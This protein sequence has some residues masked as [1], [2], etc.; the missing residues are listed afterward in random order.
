[1]DFSSTLITYLIIGVTCVISFLAFERTK[2]ME[3]GMHFPYLEERKREFYRL[4]T[5]GFL[6]GDF[7]HLAFN[8]YALYGFGG[9][10]EQWF[11]YEIPG[12]RFMY[13]VYYLLAIVLANIPTYHKHKENSQ[14]RSIGASGAV[15]AVVF[16]AILLQPNLELMIMFIP[17]PI[18]GYIFGVLYLI[19]SSYASKN[20]SDSIDHEA[21]F[22]G[23]VFGFALPA[24]LKP[25]LLTHF[26]D[27]ILS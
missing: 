18:K 13:L 20:N 11:E 16:S 15:S 21:H 9:L 26:F 10:V 2:L 7:M 24:V 22:W 27:T 3:D 6:H 12:G 5:A 8:M 17:I 19:Y 4:F 14:F 25:E 23:A 1:M